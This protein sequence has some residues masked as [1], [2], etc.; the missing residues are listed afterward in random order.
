MSRK[1]NIKQSE[2]TRTLTAVSKAG[3]KIHSLRVFPDGSIAINT[4]EDNTIG[5]FE[6][7]PWDDI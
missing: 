7:N 4:R 5:D 6:I 1:S 2:I 3:L